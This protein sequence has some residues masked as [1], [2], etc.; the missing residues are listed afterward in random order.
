MA[1]TGALSEKLL[2]LV[3]P[4]AFQQFMPA[5][6]GAAPDLDYSVIQ[7]RYGVS[8]FRLDTYVHLYPGSQ[9]F[10]FMLY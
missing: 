7:C 10:W 9:S 8:Q 1:D 5:L 3:L 4:I 6:V 2:R